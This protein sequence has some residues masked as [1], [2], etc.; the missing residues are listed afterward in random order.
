MVK[1]V[2]AKNLQECW[3]VVINSQKQFLL[4][5]RQISLEYSCVGGWNRFSFLTRRKHIFCFPDFMGYMKVSPRILPTQTSS[6]NYFLCIIPYEAEKTK[7]KIFQDLVNAL[8]IK[9]TSLFL[10]PAHIYILT[11]KIIPFFI[12]LYSWV[13]F[14]FHLFFSC[15]WWKRQP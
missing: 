7:A 13:I 11:K 9:A 14:T 8:K 10:N 15:F 2:W 12:F 6:E 1:L 3:L 4:A 5:Q